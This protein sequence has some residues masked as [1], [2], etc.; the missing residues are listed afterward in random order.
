MYVVSCLFELFPYLDHLRLNTFHSVPG[1]MNCTHFFFNRLLSKERS[2]KLASLLNVYISDTGETP[3][4]IN[5]S[6]TLSVWT[7]KSDSIVVGIEVRRYRSVDVSKE[8]DELKKC[9]VFFGHQYDCV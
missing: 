6:V 7:F 2:I 5:F 9:V 8:I 3:S 4:L 1:L